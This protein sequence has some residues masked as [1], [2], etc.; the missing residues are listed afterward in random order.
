[1]TQS[2]FVPPSSLPSHPAVWLGQLGGMLRTELLMQWR[3]L[4]FWFAFG[5]V[6]V[7]G[8]GASINV[9]NLYMTTSPFLHASP[10]FLRNDF[11]NK[12]IRST[13]ALLGIVVALLVS[14][15]M[16]RDISLHMAELQQTTSLSIRTYL[17][18]KFLGNLVAMLVPAFLVHLIFVVVTLSF[19]G[20][21]S[22]FSALGLAFVLVFPPAFAAVT[23][24]TL[25]LSTIFPLRLIQVT[26][27]FLWISLN[28][29]SE[30]GWSIAKSPFSIAGAIV[31]GHFFPHATQA[32][33]PSNTLQDV[34]L[35]IAVLSL[36][37]LICLLL[38]VVCLHLRTERR[39]L[40]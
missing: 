14:D 16:A 18:G 29:S 39:M 6:V 2:S 34:M 22:W 27:P 23:A 30:V 13:V 15:R 24:L 26:L 31:L 38:T 28:S 33:L 17:L 10:L 11:V 32:M 7:I 20:T 4:G 37:T 21:V 9:M 35:N 25:W 19:V 1:M 40:A 5:I 12:T 8:I 3:R 36:M